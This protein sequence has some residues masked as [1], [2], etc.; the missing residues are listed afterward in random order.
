MKLCDMPIALKLLLLLST[1]LLLELNEYRSYL[2]RTSAKDLEEAIVYVIEST[3]C[4][5]IRNSINWSAIIDETN[6]IT[7]KKHLAIVSWHI[8]HNLSISNS[9][10]NLHQI[11]D[12]VI[13]AL[14]YNIELDK[15]NYLAKNLL[16]E[17]DYEFVI[18]TK[19]LADLMFILTK[20][21]NIF[22]KE[23]SDLY[24]SFSIFDPKSLSIKESELENYSNKEIKKL[25]L[26]YGIDRFNSE[27]NIIKKII[28]SD[29]TK[30]E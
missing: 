26:Y 13:D 23:F 8:S 27:R 22:Q 25:S 10:K 2:S 1:N 4:E 24:Y 29:D 16:D 15:N 19:Y 17:L 7:N 28:N 9:V 12:S 20:L 14:R 21:I 11:L 6:S 5:E 30:Q 3:L 18:S